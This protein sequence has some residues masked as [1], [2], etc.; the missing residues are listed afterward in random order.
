MYFMAKVRQHQLNAQKKP[1]VH[2]ENTA[3]AVQWDKLPQEH[4][5]FKYTWEYLFGDKSPRPAWYP[6]EGELN[7][8]KDT[9]VLPRDVAAFPANNAGRRPRQSSP[10]RSLV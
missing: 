10:P 9:V 1:R 3:D 5:G 6:A 2:V 4:I 7:P 8:R